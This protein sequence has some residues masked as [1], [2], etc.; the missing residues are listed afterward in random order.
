MTFPKLT[1]RTLRVGTAALAL[2]LGAAACGDDD[3]GPEEPEPKVQTMRL[4]VGGTPYDF[5]GTTNPTIALRANTATTVTAQFLLANGQ[6]EPL[7]TAETFELRIAPT[8]ASD[9][10]F[11]RT[12]AFTGT[13]TTSRAAG[14]T[15][16]ASAEL[17]H[18]IEQHED[19]GP[20]TFSVTVTP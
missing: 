12:G 11:T 17:Y 15:F 14:Q 4:T 20:R 9:L 6:P 18:R 8:T 2:T 3:G 19:F 1:F 16:S 7:V 10:T 5:T 13:L